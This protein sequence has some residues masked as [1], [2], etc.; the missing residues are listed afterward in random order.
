MAPST[1]SSI[2]QGARD[3]THDLD[4]LRK[5][6]VGLREAGARLPDALRGANF[7]QRLNDLE[8]SVKDLRG[9]IHLIGHYRGEAGEVLKAAKRLMALEGSVGKPYGQIV[10]EAAEKERWIRG[11]EQ[12]IRELER[13]ERALTVSLGE[14]D[15]LKALSAKL[16]AHDI[17]LSQL[18]SMIE[19]GKKLGDLG[20]TPRVAHFWRKPPL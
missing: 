1:I 5:L 15:G 14:L 7:L 19:H 9:A 13:R 10:D 12:R 6:N 17:T 11:A 2:I 16:R 8:I 3:R 20:F 4:D 18:D